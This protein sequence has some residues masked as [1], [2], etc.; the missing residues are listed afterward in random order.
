MIVNL[1]I[2]QRPVFGRNSPEHDDMLIKH[3]GLLSEFT[4]PIREVAAEMMARNISTNQRS[5]NGRRSL[6]HD[7]TL[8][9]SEGYIGE[10]TVPIW[11]RYD[12][13]LWR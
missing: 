9:R 5:A 6:E 1:S 8:N 11:K 13:W 3:E 7:G 10:T 4:V 12:E 2:N